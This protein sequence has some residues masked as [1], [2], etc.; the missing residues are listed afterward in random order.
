MESSYSICPRC[1]LPINSSS[2][3]SNTEKF[4]QALGKSFHLHCF[5]CYE[6]GINISDSFCPLDEHLD[7]P[8]SIPKIFCQRHY[9][10]KMDLICER[11]NG[12]LEGLYVTGLGKKY[13][14]QHFTCSVCPTEFGP[15][16]TYYEH[17]GK[18]YCLFHYTYLVSSKCSGC[19]Q[20]IMKLYLQIYLKNEE[21]R[22]HPECYMIHK[23]WNVRIRSMA[24]PNK[25]L[26]DNTLTEPIKSI[27]EPQIY[28][29]WTVLSSFEESTAACIS[30]MLLQVSSGQYIEGLR[31][32]ER[33]IMHVDV[34][35]ASIDDLEDEL[36]QFDDSTGLQHTRE[37]KLLCKKIVGFFSVLSNTQTKSDSSG[38]TQELLTLVTSL[39]HYLKV[40]IRVALK[41]S[42]KA[43]IEYSWDN[44][45]QRLLNKLSETSDRHKWGLFRISY[46]ETDVSSDLCATCSLTVETECIE[47]IRIRKRWHLDCFTCSNCNTEMQM[48]YPSCTFDESTFSLYCPDCNKMSGIEPGG[49]RFISQ[50]EQYSFLMRVALKRLY[51]LLKF[52]SSVDVIGGKYPISKNTSSLPYIQNPIANKISSSENGK[53]SS[54][55]PSISNSY[56][57]SSTPIINSSSTANGRKSSI[58]LALE[59]V[60]SKRGVNPSGFK[61]TKED[62]DYAFDVALQ[63]V[64]DKFLIRKT[65][66][67]ANSAAEEAE[68]MGSKVQLVSP[69]N[70]SDQIYANADRRKPRVSIVSAQTLHARMKN[71]QNGTFEA[72]SLQKSSPPSNRN[73]FNEKPKH[74]LRVKRGNFPPEKPNEY[75]PSNQSTKTSKPITA[76]EE[77]KPPIPLKSSNLLPKPNVSVQKSSDLQPPT[78]NETTKASNKTTFMSDLTQLEL[79]FAKFAA[80]SKLSALLDPSGTAANGVS[81]EILLILGVSK[82]QSGSVWGK[83]RSNLKN[84][85]GVKK[86]ADKEKD[87][88]F[89]KS[90]TFGVALENLIEIQ[91]AETTLGTRGSKNLFIPSFFDKMI[92]TLEGMDLAVEGIFR[93]NGNIRRLREVSKAADK[94]HKLVNLNQDNSVQVAALLK[95]FCREIPDPI[96]PFRMRKLFLDINASIESPDA[97]LLAYQ[98]ALLLLPQ[99]NRDMLNALLSFLKSVSAY[100]YVD[101]NVGSKMN[102]KN[103]A[104]V[105]TPNIMYADIKESNKDD[106]YSYA[107]TNVIHSLIDF[108]PSVWQ[109]PN[110]IVNFLRNQDLYKLGFDDELVDVNSGV[111]SSS[112]SFALIPNKSQMSGPN[113]NSIANNGISFSSNNLSSN[114][115]GLN[116]ISSPLVSNSTNIISPNNSSGAISGSISGS[117]NSNSNSNTLPGNI[118][119]EGNYSMLPGYEFVN[120]DLNPAEILKRCETYGLLSPIVNAP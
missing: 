99:P 18:A 82:K 41:G 28:Q 106:T 103:L 10:E 87:Q 72:V 91:G 64:D 66:L 104:L 17:E 37:P 78:Q 42:L 90:G 6:C 74:I 8:D 16:G 30:D 24:S 2:D 39:A 58:H 38:L 79:F 77:T 53:Q 105:I 14:P 29:I 68:A 21:E 61:T 113:I 115:M 47:Y 54:A 89:I 12:T 22:W 85:A 45:T 111:G 35:F 95:K 83:L 7:S 110:S 69:K 43:E 119:A 92:T 108:T 46:Q 33:F 31:Q 98:C 86:T 93:K 71:A 81:N 19:Q 40:L 67:K 34:L 101:E 36:A 50:L 70:M 20:P 56:T 80:S 65:R 23:F 84:A 3:S 4:V 107:A 76:I 73:N 52:R 25:S 44:S 11:C 59:E 118:L 114:S 27:G 96:V 49:F 100:S 63:K 26:N 117:I 116:S 60:A 57:T 109:V 97:L 62:A 112:Q 102:S 32:A 75:L 5:T 1:N 9:Y 120:A 48:I 51:G 13:H 88:K 55:S 94:D 15:D